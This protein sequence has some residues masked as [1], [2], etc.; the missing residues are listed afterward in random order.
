MLHKTQG[1]VLGVAKYS[2]KFSIVQVFTRDFGRVA[3]LLPKAQG[4]KSKIKQSLFFP[5][6]VLDMQ[7]EHLPLREIQRLKDVE[8]QIPLY[9]VCTH[10]TKTS[11]VFFLAEFLA[12]VLRE[13]HDNELVYDYLRNSVETLEALNRGVANFHLALLFGL[14]RFLGIYPNLDNYRR[15]AYFDLINSEF[16]PFRPVHNQYLTPAQSDFLRLLSRINYGNMHLYKLSR[17]D[18][19]AILEQLITYYRLHVCDF[20]PLKSLDVLREMG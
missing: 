2:D 9:D 18:R 4:R 16:S 17:S 5:L 20:P 15:N 6:S 3:Y 13:T 19:N 14:T 7:V 11:V 8:R 10:I 12:K 1:I